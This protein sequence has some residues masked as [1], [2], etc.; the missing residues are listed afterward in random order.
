M[1]LQL[2]SDLH[3]ESIEK[4]FFG[5]RLIQ[6]NPDAD[7][8]VLA[9][10]IA[11][12]V[13]ALELFKDWPVPVL[14][15]A[16]N[17]EFYGLEVQRTKQ[18]LRSYTK[19]GNVT[20]LDNAS[21]EFGGVRFLG[22]T[23]WT[24]YRIPSDIPQTELMAFSDENYPDHGHIRFGNEKFSSKH[25]LA[26]H[27][28]SVLWLE[29]ELA[30]PYA[31]KTVVISHHAPHGKSVHPRF[32]DSPMNAS[33][34][35][36][37]NSL[38]EQTDFWLHGHVHDTM[39]YQYERCRIFANPRGY[40]LNLRQTDQLENI[41]FENTEF[42]HSGLIDLTVGDPIAK[43]LST[44]EFDF[45]VPLDDETRRVEE[46][47]SLIKLNK[48]LSLDLQ[49]ERNRLREILDNFPGGVSMLDRNL[50]FVGW[51]KKMLSAMETPPELFSHAI[52]PTLEQGIQSNI[53]RGEYGE[54]DAAACLTQKMDLAA[55]FEPHVFE[56]IR[57]DGSVLE[58]RGIPM[59]C[60]GF[61][62]TYQDITPNYLLRQELKSS[63]LISEEANKNLAETLLVLRETQAKLIQSEKLA[64][65]GRI[66]AGVAH[67]INTPIGNALMVA[68]TLQ[69]KTEEL[70]SNVTK[71]LLK[72]SDLQNFLNRDF[73]T[74]E[75]LI[76]NLQRA[77]DLVAR[78]KEIA[79]DRPSETHSDFNLI[80]VVL[81]AIESIS[82][83]EVKFELTIEKN[84]PLGLNMNSFRSLLRTVL[85]NLVNNCV[86]HSFEG[87]SAGCIRIDGLA[88]SSE[89]LELS[90]RDNGIGI[91]ADNLTRIFDPFF[92]T[93]LGAGGFGLGLFI[94]H[95]IVTTILGGSIEVTSEFGQG[96]TF[97]I[98]L[99]FQ[100]P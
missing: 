91:E 72:K 92:T 74:L 52:L 86:I 69:F 48:Q 26:E 1:K 6:A 10:D 18:Q 25:A 9:G 49:E 84:I 17:H 59:E 55:R 41:Q 62:T 42:R 70:K 40:A 77:G 20:V 100:A 57:P 99:P 82:G 83:A 19:G 43:F 51:N 98:A 94:V 11:S 32:A 90:V 5:E 78:F 12:G 60:G 4:A 31:G 46:L 39:A 96:T 23:L 35:S 16:G 14:F 63:L 73:E 76:R 3:L 67:E 66:V 50:R 79:I 54:V 47:D 93:K 64:A 21:V 89:M 33:F 37:L 58:V 80:D 28:K 30:R 45:A 61:V 34:V 29:R 87:R 36:D 95:N 65:L 38:V 7:L 85:L 88:L 53:E 68:S 71:G 81:E 44:S 2:V 75:V 13:R 15:V 56:R 22:A 8:L 24:D 97:T 27:N